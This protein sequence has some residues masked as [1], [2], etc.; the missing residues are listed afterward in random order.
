M[1]VNY[2]HW[3]QFTY[4]NVYHRLTCILTLNFKLSYLF[5][6]ICTENNFQ[7]DFLLMLLFEIFK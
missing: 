1:D 2:S 3:E 7:R 6:E 5:Y 4:I